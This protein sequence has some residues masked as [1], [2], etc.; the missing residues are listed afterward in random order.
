MSGLI[1]IAFTTA[2]RI[3]ALRDDV[4]RFGGTFPFFGMV[5]ITKYF[6]RAV[7]KLVKKMSKYNITLCQA[8][9]KKLL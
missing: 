5:V 2:A 7:Y 3:D 8:I 4:G 9:Y 1:N 6:Y